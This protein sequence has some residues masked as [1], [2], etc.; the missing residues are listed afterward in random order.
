MAAAKNN[1]LDA[2]GGLGFIWTRITRRRKPWPPRLG[3]RPV[4]CA[5]WRSTWGPTTRRSYLEET[6]CWS[7]PAECCAERRGPVH[8]RSWGK[9][10]GGRVR[11]YCWRALRRPE[12]IHK[13]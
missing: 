9:R 12:E 6:G 7:G 3:Q 4:W 5:T 11:S 8:R 1:T 13:A 10:T 2:R